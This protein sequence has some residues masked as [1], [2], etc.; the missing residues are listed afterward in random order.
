MRRKKK[1]TIVTVESRERMTIRHSARQVFAWCERC[2]A[3]VLMVTAT[4]AAAIAQ[5]DVRAIFRQ[6]ELGEIHFIERE[7]AALLVCSNSLRTTQ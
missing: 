7:G 6:V 4:E 2:G 5:V 3:D 1:T